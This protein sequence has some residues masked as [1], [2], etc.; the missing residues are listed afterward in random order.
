METTLTTADKEYLVNLARQTLYWYLKD[1]V[2]PSPDESILSDNVRQKCACFVTLDKRDVGLRGC[3]GLFERDR[4]LYKNVIDRA[5]TA[6]TKDPRF[7]QV[8]YHELKDIRVEISVLTEPKPLQFDS[9]HDLLEKL[10]SLVDGVILRTRYGF[11]QS[12]FL[13][14]VWKQLPD[15]KD[16]LS[17]LCLKQHAPADAW[18]SDY[19]NVRIWTYQ[20]IVFG[21]ETYG[22]IVV[23]KDGAVVGEMGAYLLGTTGS[24]LENLHQGHRITKGTELEP[25]TIVTPDSDIIEH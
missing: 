16:F 18:I 2:V 13:P 15:K 20:A 25:G 1:G 9:P 19:K 22:R 11:Q 17:R 3:M 7:M 12:T 5:I 8:Q 21:E 4:P 24:T 23:G 10:R 6:A 14:Q